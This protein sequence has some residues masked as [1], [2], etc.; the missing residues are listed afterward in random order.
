MRKFLLLFGAMLLSY[1]AFSQIGESC[2]NP[3]TITTLPYSTTGSTFGTTA[4]DFTG[5]DDSYVMRSGN[6]VYK[7]S[8]SSDMVINVSI[9]NIARTYEPEASTTASY[10][11]PASVGLFAYKS[12]PDATGAEY[13][14]D[15]VFTNRLQT[16]GTLENLELTS[17]NDYYFIIA[18][19]SLVT[20]GSFIS[21]ANACYTTASYSLSIER[22]MQNDFSITAVSVADAGCEATTTV[23]Y[24][25]KNTGRVNASSVVVECRVGETLA[26]SETLTNIAVDSTAQ[27]TFENVS[28]GLGSNTIT[29]TAIMAGDENSSND[30]KDVVAM[31]KPTI[32][33]FPYSVDFENVEYWSIGGTRSSWEFAEAAS[34]TINNSDGVCAIT[35]STGN[36][37]TNENSYI[38]GPCFDFSTLVS[39]ILE[40]DYWLPAGS[41]TNYGSGASVVVSTDGAVWDTISL[42]SNS[43]WERSQISLS[44]Y[45]GSPLVMIRFCYKG[46]YLSATEGVAIDNVLVRETF[47]NDMGITAIISPVSGCGVSSQDFT[48]EI[49]NFGIAPQSN[50]VIEYSTDGTNWMTETANIT[51]PA[52]ETANYTFSAGVDMS[53]I[54]IHTLYVRTSND[55]DNSNNMIT[56]DIFVQNSI[57]VDGSYVEGFD[58]ATSDWYANGSNSSWVYGIPSGYA[59]SHEN[60]ENAWG[61]NLSGYANSNEV[62]YLY[63]S[64]Y[65]LSE[66]SSPRLEM[67]FAYNLA[68]SESIG[69]YIG[70]GNTLA[71]QYSLDGENWT[72]LPTGDASENW[73]AQGENAWMGNSNG[74]INASTTIPFLAGQPYVKFRFYF[75]A[76]SSI[77]SLIDQEPIEGVAISSFAISDCNTPAPVA[78]FTFSTTECSGLVQFT[79][80]STNAT[81]YMWNLGVAT[82]VLIQTE[83]T[84]TEENPSYE[85][86]ESGSYTVVL[87]AYN[88]CGADMATQVVTVDLC[89]TSID[90]QSANINIYPNPA[91]TMINIENIKCDNIKI[92]N[93]LG[94]VVS[95]IDNANENV[96]IDVRQYSNGTYY[97]KANE[98]VYRFN[99][100]K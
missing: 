36:A 56:A 37:N 81:S 61:T 25:F 82:G 70:M 96:T 87:H 13:M 100:V 58:G 44:T 65:N 76:E 86:P 66:L 78:N 20:A 89:E 9:S 85:Y 34:S 91:N 30:S 31:R 14:D 52:G 6:Y 1:V 17:G 75:N 59:I 3:E 60:G 64:C 33:T 69:E 18:V 73:Y 46:A 71:L 40:F 21:Q 72:Y 57:D 2:A 48:V 45:A 63:T 53:E 12:C 29:V 50:F 79:N 7:F 15:I 26:V 93:S 22:I 80:N 24:S 49:T 99:V 54:G 28:L 90:E 41:I 94:Q 98:S 67:R 97:I 32:A 23:T 4:Y 43:G 19:D 10:L 39:P 88:E 51:V 27:R 16:S 92:I 42:S 5:I 95:V 74:W 68:G 62:S 83:E 11:S 47:S 35:S 84:S 38:A 55:E 8:P 77:I